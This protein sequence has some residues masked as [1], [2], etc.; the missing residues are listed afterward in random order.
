MYCVL[1]KLVVCIS[2]YFSKEK[3]FCFFVVLALIPQLYI[4][5]EKNIGTVFENAVIFERGVVG[6]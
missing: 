5:L 4:L 2:T 6:L 3:Y 1:I